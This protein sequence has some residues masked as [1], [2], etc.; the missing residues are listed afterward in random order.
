MNIVDT[1]SPYA[2]KVART[3]DGKVNL[4]AYLGLPALFQAGDLTIETIIRD[5]RT[6]FGHLDLLV[7]PSAGSGS[8]WVE[9]KNLNIPNDPA[10]FSPAVTSVPVEETT[11][12]LT[13][14]VREI[15]NRSEI[16]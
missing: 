15:I 2:T 12:S 10:H 3:P 4:S 5:A 8:R 14:E 11:R 13:D 16:K 7:E 1:A 6:R 9:R